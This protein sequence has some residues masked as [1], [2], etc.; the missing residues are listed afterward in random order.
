MKK[1]ILVLLVIFFEKPVATAQQDSTLIEKYRE[2]KS[3]ESAQ[4]EKERL[5]RQSLFQY[6]DHH[7]VTGQE[8]ASDYINFAEK[9]IERWK[10][11][12]ENPEVLFLEMETLEVVEMIKAHTESNLTAQER[13]ERLK[14]EL[15]VKIKEH[16]QKLSEDIRE[17]SG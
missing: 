3:L 17:L 11:A 12:L 14:E 4:H 10:I 1:L 5:L 2:F 8:V 6:V 16:I 13:I 15:R 9:A 7:K